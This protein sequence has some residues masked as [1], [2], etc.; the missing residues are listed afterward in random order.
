MNQLT[1]DSL[2]ILRI[3]LF[4]MIIL[5]FRCFRNYCF[6]TLSLKFAPIS[7]KDSVFSVN[8]LLQAFLSRNIYNPKLTLLILYVIIKNQVLLSGK[9]LKKS[10]VAWNL[11]IF[12]LSWIYFHLFWN[13]LLW[14]IYL[15]LLIIIIY[16]ILSFIAIF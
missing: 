1:N 3:K 10:G 12:I 9:S 7:I 6:F 15:N 14:R 5:W 4:F 16:L 13:L 11:M 8:Y 2:F